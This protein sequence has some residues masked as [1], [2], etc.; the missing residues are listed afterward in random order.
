MTRE[1]IATVSK[2]FADNNVQFIHDDYKC[3]LKYA[4]KGDLVYFDPPYDVEAGINGFIH[5]SVN[6]F[7]RAQQ[8]ELKAI[9]DS[10]IKTGARVAISNSGT[11]YIKELYNDRR[12]AINVLNVQRNIGASVESRKE[13]EEVL[14]IGE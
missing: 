9:C 1:Q 5:Y 12:Y 14:I 3:V 6:R 11:D 2:F 13:Y 7:A 8:L 4:K 10:L